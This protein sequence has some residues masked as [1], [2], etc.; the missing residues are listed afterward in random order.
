M[1]SF[2]HIFEILNICSVSWQ[3]FVK[4]PWESKIKYLYTVQKYDT[5]KYT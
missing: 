1:N 5:E 4:C 3:W 2:K